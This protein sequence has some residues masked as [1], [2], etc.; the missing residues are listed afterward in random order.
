[1][2]RPYPPKD[3]GLFN[4]GDDH[5][6]SPAPAPDFADWLFS[7]IFAPDGELH[8]IS[9]IMNSQP[10]IVCS[11]F[12]IRFAIFLVPVNGRLIAESY[13]FRWTG[14]YWGFVQAGWR[15]RRIVVNCRYPH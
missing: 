12:E 7:T 15:Y 5:P 3:L 9:A 8:T 14:R 6:I 10:Y 11:A 13:Y 2:N 1:M 4:K